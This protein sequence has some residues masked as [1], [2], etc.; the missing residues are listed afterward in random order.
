MRFLAAK[1]GWIAARLAA[2]PQLVRFAEGVIVPVL[3]IPHRILRE[4]DPTAPPVAIRDGEIRVRG[5]AVH[6]ERRVRDHLVAM[7]RTEFAAR[8]RPLAARIERK[9]ARVGALRVQRVVD[10]RL[11]R[12]VVRGQRPVLEPLWDEEPRASVGLHDERVV[13]GD[14]VLRLGAVG[15]DVVGRLVLLEVGVVAAGPPALGGVPPHIALALGPGLPVGVGGCPVVEDAGVGRP[16][17]S[18]LAR[19]PVLLPVRR[20]A[21]R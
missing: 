21:R 5:D 11:V 4:D 19:D 9:L 7:A 2:L 18:P 16:G 15:R 1:Q 14:G 3:G 17:P 13:A 6:I 20:P 8:A 10:R 12:L